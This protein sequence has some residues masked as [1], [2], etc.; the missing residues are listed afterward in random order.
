[1]TQSSALYPGEVMHKRLRPKK[2]HMTYKVF[3]LFLDLDELPAL[4][5]TLKLFGHNRWAPVSF[6][7]A[8]HGD[9]SRTGLKNWV[10]GKLAE[11][12]LAEPKMTI[13]ILCYP[14]VFGYVFNPLTLFFCRNQAGALRAVLYEVSNTFHER[15]TYIIPVQEAQETIRQ[16][17]AKEFY[18]SPFMPMNCTYDFYIEAPSETTL[19]RIE[20]ADPEGMML[21][22]SFKGKRVE[23]SDATIARMLFRH[24]LMTLKVTAGIYW[25]ALKLWKKGLPIFRHASGAPKI[26]SSVISPLNDKR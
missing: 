15:H 17:C 22:A 10:E 19:I 4:G 12:G 8:D 24:P 21:I 6:H 18:V 9:G 3:S 11:A 2:H 1:M 16:G 26:S 14:R 13:E 5:K 20:E 23:M 7:E 25:E